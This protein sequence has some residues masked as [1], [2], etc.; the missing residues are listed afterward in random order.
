MRF[1]AHPGRGELTGDRVSGVDS[2]TRADEGVR[3]L[4]QRR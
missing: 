2:L 4:N 3:N 1:L